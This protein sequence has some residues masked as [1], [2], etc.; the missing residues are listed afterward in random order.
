MLPRHLP[1]S[2]K[3]VIKTKI[4]QWKTDIDVP[5]FKVALD[6]LNKPGDFRKFIKQDTVL[7]ELRSEHWKEL[8]T[9]LYE[10]VKGFYE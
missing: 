4:A 7:N 10:M 5:L 9:E 2:A 1:E 6:E 3:D 8:N